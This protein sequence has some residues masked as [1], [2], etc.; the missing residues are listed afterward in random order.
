MNRRRKV[1]LKTATRL[2][3]PV[4]NLVRSLKHF[5]EESENAV[6][7]VLLHEIAIARGIQSPTWPDGSQ[8]ITD[9][10]VKQAGL[11]AGSFRLV[12]GSG[13]SR[14][15]LIAADSSTRL[16]AFMKRHKHWPTFIDSL[17]IYEVNVASSDGKPEPRVSAK[18]GSMSGVSTCSG[19][20]RTSA[21]RELAFSYLTNGF[22]GRSTPQ[23]ELRSAIWE[24][25]IRH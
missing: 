18:G 21:G 10:L 8:A 19:I 5:N 24:L 22:I 20:V 2:F 9:W 15:N 25:L 3:S 6:G 1:R 16:L 13:L 7:E 12:D 14:Y 17:P 11:E 23:K 4:G